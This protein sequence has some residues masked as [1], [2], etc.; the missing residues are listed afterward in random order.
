MVLDNQLNVDFEPTIFGSYTFLTPVDYEVYP[1]NGGAMIS[2]SGSEIMFTVGD[3][4]RYKYPC[5]YNELTIEREYTMDGQ[6]TSEIGDN[7]DLGFVMKAGG[8]KVDIPG[9]TI[10]P[11]ASF[12]ESI[13]Y[14]CVCSGEE[15]LFGICVPYVYPC[16]KYKTISVDIPSIG[17]DGTELSTCSV[18]N[19][20]PGANCD[21]ST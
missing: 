18:Y 4:I 10:F 21:A 12:S 3:S 8:V 14:P 6:V 11:G 20:I 9:F 13:P 17:F 15:C 2:G 19:L 1:S 16:I 7:F 5:F